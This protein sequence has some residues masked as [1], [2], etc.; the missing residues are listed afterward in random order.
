M[1]CSN[2]SHIGTSKFTEKDLCF[3]LDTKKGC[4]AT[5]LHPLVTWRKSFEK[6]RFMVTWTLQKKSKFIPSYKDIR[7]NMVNKS[8]CIPIYAYLY[9]YS[10]FYYMLKSQWKLHCLITF[11]RHVICNLALLVFRVNEP[12]DQWTRPG[13]KVKISNS[14]HRA[15]RLDRPNVFDFS[16]FCKNDYR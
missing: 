1:T 12:F 2:N 14:P 7:K 11:T 8:P 10:L 6:H 5:E 15:S 4:I 13:P 3:H 16:H 9:L